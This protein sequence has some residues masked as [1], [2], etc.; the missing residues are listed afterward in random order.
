MDGFIKIYRSLFDNWLW[1][2]KPFSKGQAW[3]DLLQLANISDSQ[4]LIKGRVITIKR[5]QVF[6]PL[7]ALSKRWGWGK[8]KTR[9]FLSLLEN[10]KMVT[11][12]GT[13]GGTLITIVKYANY[14][15]LGQESGI[16]EDTSEGTQRARKG[17]GNKK[18]K[19]NKK[20][21]YI[22]V[23]DWIHD[24]IPEELQ[25]DF[26]TWADMRKQIKKPIVTEET[27]RRRYNTLMRLSKNPETQKRIIRQSIDR[28]WAD[29]YELKDKEQAPRYK[30]FEKEEPTQGVEMPEEIRQ[31]LNKIF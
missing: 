11:T 18:N 1:E 15:P 2:E 30:E 26:K 10:Q 20:N 27:V 14:N 12:E 3:I 13:T 22:G 8:K 23:E 29:F 5:G 31:N 17:H 9:L 6:R 25:A 21:K 19:K 4:A 16:T 24:I 28:C 7:D